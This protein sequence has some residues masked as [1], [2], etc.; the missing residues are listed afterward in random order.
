MTTPDAGRV[1]ARIVTPG[2][3]TE[4]DL[5]PS[6]RHT[7]IRTAVRRAVRA[8]PGLEGNAVRLIVLLDDISRR[9][10]DSGGFYCASLVLHDLGSGGLLV[11]NALMQVTPDAD[12]PLPIGA[13]A[14]ELCAGLAAAVSCDPDWE[15][16]EVTVVQL[17]LVGP[18]VRVGVVAGGVLVQ[19]LVPV[20]R[21]NRQVVLTLS[22]PCPLYVGAFIDLFDAMASSLALEFAVAPVIHGPAA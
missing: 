5:D 15:G 21:T 13:T 7:S 14:T 10:C 18:A 12:P 17:P 22:C 6:T 11:A 3:W 20:P 4:L 16:A 9:A 1:A 2:D 8:D 19:H